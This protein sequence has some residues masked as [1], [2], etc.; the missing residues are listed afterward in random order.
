MD[1]FV[2]DRDAL[3]SWIQLSK[4]SQNALIVSSLGKIQIPSSLTIKALKKNK[5][6]FTVRTQEEIL[7]RMNEIKDDDFFGFETGDL[8]DYLDFEHAQPFL[9][10]DVVKK[11]W[12]DRDKFTPEERIKDYM[13][14]AWEKANNKRG[15]SASRSI[16]HMRAWLWL[17]GNQ[18]L[19]DFSNEDDNYAPYGKPILS[20][21]CEY[22]GLTDQDN[23][24]TSCS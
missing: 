22:Y 21:I 9:Q 3:E 6:E 19:L 15:I 10:E 16:S 17:A 1:S 8:V 5:K 2:Q 4:K 13:N 14:F 20:K 24:D 23:G 11:Q 7:A 12:E 18:E